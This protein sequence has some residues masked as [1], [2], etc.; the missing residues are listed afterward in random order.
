[1]DMPSYSNRSK[2]PT[3]LASAHTSLRWTTWA[4]DFGTEM[5]WGQ[6]CAR[7]RFQCTTP[8]CNEKNLTLHH[9]KYK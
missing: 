7:D 5:K 4:P 8:V 9:M 6:I 1:M 3:C 2:E